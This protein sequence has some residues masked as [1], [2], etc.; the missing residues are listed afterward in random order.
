MSS[1]SVQ[2]METLEY[3]DFIGG[4]TKIRVGLEVGIFCVF[5]LDTVSSLNLTRR[6]FLRNSMK[7]FKFRGDSRYDIVY[8]GNRK[9]KTGLI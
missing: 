8:L 5:Q 6:P 4:E 7:L 3:F 9:H 2:D 1:S